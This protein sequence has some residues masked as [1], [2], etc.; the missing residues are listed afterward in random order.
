MQLICRACVNMYD[1]DRETPI[2]PQ[3]R[4]YIKFRA[5]DQA[6]YDRIAAEAEAGTYVCRSY[7]RGE[8]AK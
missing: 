8:G 4:Q 2:L 7:P 5:I 3:A 6:E 1:P